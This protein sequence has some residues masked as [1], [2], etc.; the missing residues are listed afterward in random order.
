MN[1]F[2]R[3]V[4][5]RVGGTTINALLP[6]IKNKHPQLPRKIFITQLSDENMILMVMV[7]SN[8]TRVGKMLDV[9]NEMA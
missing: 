7:P 3:F 2:R 1:T 4:E 8:A 9:M 6:M 5:W